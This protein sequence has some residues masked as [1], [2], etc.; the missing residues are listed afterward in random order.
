MN[1]KTSSMWV[2]S[3]AKYH[4][5]Q[6]IWSVMYVIIAWRYTLAHASPDILTNG[7]GFDKTYHTFIF[8]ALMYLLITAAYIIFGV[9]KINEWDKRDTIYS[10]ITTILCAPIG[11]G[12]FV[13]LYRVIH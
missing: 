11:T 3:K 12:L 2:I 9:K 1:P 13:M 10:V 7:E 8:T 5:C 4:I 6:I